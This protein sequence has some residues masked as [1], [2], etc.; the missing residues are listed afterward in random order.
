MDW[1]SLRRL[2]VGWCAAFVLLAAASGGKARAQESRLNS[3]RA[4]VAAAAG[5]RDA[6]RSSLAL[7]RALRRAGRTDAAVVEL[8]RALG[9]AGAQREATI[10]IDQELARAYGDRREVAAALGVCT[11]IGKLS[12]AAALGHAC[13]A[14][15]ELVRERA[16]LALGETSSALALDPV[17]FEAKL[18]EGRAHSMGLNWL[19]ADE[20]LRAA[21]AMQPD[22]PEAHLAFGRALLQEGRGPDAVV[23]LRRAVTLDPDGPEAL[24]ALALALPPGAERAALLER[25]TRERAPFAPAWLALGEAR[26]A[27]GRVEEARA[28]SDVALR[29]DPAKPDVKLLAGEIA[30]AQGRID[31]AARAAQDVL[32]VAPNRAAAKLLLAD[33]DAK[34]GDIDGAIDAYQAAWG[35][36]STDPTP[37]VRGSRACREAGR[38]TTAL[39]FAERA[40]QDFPDWAP[41]WVELGDAHAARGERSDAREAYTRALAAGKGPIDREAI[42]KRAAA[43]R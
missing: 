29:L 15:V 41:G 40:T 23:E 22:A 1:S 25:V 3:L 6:W 37:L 10:A 43:A 27:E 13:T 36:D 7:G 39:A 33:A 12:G 5:G 20:S 2:A 30:L 42:A 32:R 16:S 31:D 38:H 14:E 18:A 4:E 9:L 28:A 34:K 21:I 19:A 17:C 26:L 24:F 35:F 8:R 11:K